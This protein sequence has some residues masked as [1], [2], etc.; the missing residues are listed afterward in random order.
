MA[1]FTFFFSLGYGARFLRPIF[2]QAK[3]WQVL[4]VIIGVIMLS[5]ALSLVI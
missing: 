5:L 3:S 2:A 1:S 4:E